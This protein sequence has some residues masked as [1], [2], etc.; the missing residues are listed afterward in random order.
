MT[1]YRTNAAT[2]STPPVPPLRPPVCRCERRTYWQIHPW[3]MPRRWW[4]GALFGGLLA[5][6]GLDL[7]DWRYWVIMVAAAGWS[8]WEHERGAEWGWWP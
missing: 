6:C 1:V 4:K 2:A 3:Y 7:A 8:T 5:V